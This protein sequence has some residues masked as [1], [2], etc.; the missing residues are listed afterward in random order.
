MKKS[1]S[2][3]IKLFCVSLIIF[4]CSLQKKIYSPGYH[5]VWNGSNTSAKKTEKLEKIS[6]EFNSEQAF[7]QGIIENSNDIA[8]NN[9]DDFEQLT[10][11]TVLDKPCDTLIKRNGERIVGVVYE[12]GINEVKYYKC[13]MQ[14]GAIFFIGKADLS[15][16]IFSNGTEEKFEMSENSSVQEFPS[17]ENTKPRSATSSNPQIQAALDKANRKTDGFA[18]AGFVASFV[19][20]FVAGIILGVVAIVFGAVGLSRIS[21][22]PVNRKG[23]GLAVA[24]ITLGVLVVIL[25]LLLIATL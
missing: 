8:S 11:K 14:D 15:K 25:T 10:L 18:I 9:V 12:V 6:H 24:A 19:G 17:Y 5:I 16:I 22:D 3:F 7:Y 13:R 4:S 1:F 23:S 2:I 21:K 20:I